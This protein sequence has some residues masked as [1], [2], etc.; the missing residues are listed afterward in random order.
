M[1]GK[2]API[3]S[4]NKG[5]HAGPGDSAVAIQGHSG[6]HWGTQ[7]GA[8]QRLV[9]RT[10]DPSPQHHWCRQVTREAAPGLLAL[11]PTLKPRPSP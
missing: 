5:G 9:A 11:A 6:W 1:N 2:N 10:G 8:S 7:G 4:K 3:W